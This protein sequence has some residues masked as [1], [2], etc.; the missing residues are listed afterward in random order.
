MGEPSVEHPLTKRNLENFGY[1]AFSSPASSTDL[2]DDWLAR[3]KRQTYHILWS[4]DKIGTEGKRI[5]QDEDLY[6]VDYGV[7]YRGAKKPTPDLEDVAF[8][9]AKLHE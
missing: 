3:A 9:D 2:P 1:E 4:L 5:L 8:W 7:R 6:V